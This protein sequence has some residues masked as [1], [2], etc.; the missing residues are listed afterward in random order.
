MLDFDF[1][2][3]T[4]L[5]APVVFF[6]LRHHSPTAARLVR[7]LTQTMRPAAVL[8]ECPADFDDRLDELYLP[9]QPPLAVYSYVRLPD[10]SAPTDI[11]YLMRDGISVTRSSVFLTW[12]S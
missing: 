8:V 10:G 6:P 7:R 3:L 4:D 11:Q 2:P 5:S 12:G 9:H 1:A